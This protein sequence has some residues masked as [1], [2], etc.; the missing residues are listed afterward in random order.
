MFHRI[1]KLIHIQEHPPA[2]ILPAELKQPP[3][4][5]AVSVCMN[6]QGVMCFLIICTGFKKNVFIRQ[7][8]VFLKESG[9]CIGAEQ[10]AALTDFF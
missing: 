4:K 3:E 1:A 8:V 2:E 7:T 9:D 6:G 10:Q 5:A